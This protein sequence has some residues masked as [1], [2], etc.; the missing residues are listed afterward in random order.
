MAWL[1]LWRWK[2]GSLFGRRLEV[3]TADGRPTNPFALE[4][5]SRDRTHHK[6]TRDHDEAEQIVTQTY[7]PHRLL[8]TAGAGIDMKL[9][10][11]RFGEVTAGLLSYGQTVH[12][13]TADTTQFHVNVTLSGRA[14]S[15]AGN[16]DPLLTTAGQAMVFPVGQPAQIKW[17]TDARHLCLMASR[18]SLEGEL[19]QLLGRSLPT[20][21]AFERG[22]R[23]EV[24]RLWQPALELVQQE[25]DDPQG[26]LTRP[27]V[28][29]HLEG[30]VC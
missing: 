10:S 25:L 1:G 20:R 3:S 19:E 4:P 27:L 7:L 21:L 29:R 8:T 11:A 24:S 17:S 14:A 23:T 26:L 30:L 2:Y 12:L 13:Q 28:A 9:A 18:A 15:R 5:S 22:L 6:Q 16:E